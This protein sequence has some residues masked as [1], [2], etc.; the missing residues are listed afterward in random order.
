MRLPRAYLTT[1]PAAA[2]VS[3]SIASASLNIPVLWSVVAGVAVW[4]G[5]LL[6]TWP[7]NG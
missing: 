1:I 7:R 4:G 3:A 5:L 2:L 6:L